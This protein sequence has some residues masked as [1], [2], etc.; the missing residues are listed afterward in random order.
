MLDVA[1]RHADSLSNSR[2]KS[3][4]IASA[5]EQPV[6]P[7]YI[8][9]QYGPILV[10][11]KPFY[12]RNIVRFDVIRVVV[13]STVYGIEPVVAFVSLSD[14]L[15]HLTHVFCPPTFMIRRVPKMLN[16]TAKKV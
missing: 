4:P 12:K 3:A 15:N 6:E 8:I 7:A 9:E 10:N 1:A 5:A 13:R 2:P 16:A 14:F 11:V